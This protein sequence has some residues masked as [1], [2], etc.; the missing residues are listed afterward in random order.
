MSDPR[1]PIGR[2]EPPAAPTAATR[3]CALTGI[4]GLPALLHET[5]RGLDNAQLDTPYRDGGW[6]VRQVVHHVADSHVNAYARIRLLLT[7]DHP[8][9]RPYA[10][11]AW[12]ELADARDGAVGGSLLLLTALHE[13][14]THCLRALPAAAFARTLHH[15]EAGRDFS[16]D[17]MVAMYD[18]HGRHHVAHIAG[19]RARRGW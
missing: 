16:L 15:P 5:V 11:A 6:T 8:T 3:V 2:F 19:L 1:Y 12:A 7:E 13:R 17:D 9:I 14:W 10:E 18:W 4:A